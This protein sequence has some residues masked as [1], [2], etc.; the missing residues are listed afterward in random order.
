M[1]DASLRTASLAIIFIHPKITKKYQLIN[2]NYIRAYWKICL[3]ESDSKHKMKS[4][5]YLQSVVFVP[6]HYA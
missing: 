3:L 6:S 2:I 4:N 5:G 1:S